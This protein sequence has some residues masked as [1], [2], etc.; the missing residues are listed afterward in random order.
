MATTRS[1]TELV[2]ALL[3]LAFC[4]LPAQDS[5]APQRIEGPWLAFHGQELPLEALHKYQLVV[6]LAGDSPPILRYLADPTRIVAG[7]A[8]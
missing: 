3:L 7:Q 8:R 2:I 1:R 4:A 6:V 5:D